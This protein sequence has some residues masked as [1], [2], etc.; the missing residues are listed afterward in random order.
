M[1][2]LYSGGALQKS[3]VEHVANA[4][5]RVHPHFVEIRQVLAPAWSELSA[6]MEANLPKYPHETE[7]CMG[8]PQ[9]RSS[10]S[11][12]LIYKN[13]ANP[14][15]GAFLGFRSLAEHEKF[16]E[17]FEGYIVNKTPFHTIFEAKA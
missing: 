4:M 14:A 8:Q 11:T 7:D 17:A 10:V 6:W 13:F 12:I 16:V 9:T 2:F 3:T 5:S 15:E 1:M